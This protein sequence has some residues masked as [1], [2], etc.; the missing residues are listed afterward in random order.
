MYVKYIFKNIFEN[1][2][3]EKVKMGVKHCQK[4]EAIAHF[5]RLIIEEKKPP[6]KS[7]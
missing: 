6:T 2:F 5:E 7:E 4:K 1:F 3:P